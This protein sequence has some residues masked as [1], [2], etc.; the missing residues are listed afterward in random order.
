MKVSTPQYLW[1]QRTIIYQIYPRSFQDSNGDGIGDLQGIIIRLNYLQSLG[2][3]AIWLSPIFPSP[4]ADFGYDISDYTGI[5]SLFGTMEDFDQLLSDIHE[6]GMK[7]IL[8][9]VPN[10]SSDQHPWFLESRS[11]KD[12]PKRDWYI[13]HDAKA[14][15][16]PPNNWLSVFGGGA[17]EWDHTTNQYYY[18][19]FL[20]EQPDLNWRNPELQKAMLD[21]MRFWL[22]KGVDGFRVDVMWY[23][24]KDQEL[25]DNPVNPHYEQHRP[26]SEQ[27]IDVYST[28]QPEVLEIVKRM[29]EVLDEY[30]ERMMIGEIYLPI[31]RL[32]RYYGKSNDGAHL[33]FNF[34]LLSLPWDAEKIAAAIDEYEAALPPDGWPNWVLGNHDRLRLV[35]R[36]GLNQARIAAMLLLTLRGTPTIY[37]GEEIGMQDVNIPFEEIQ[38]PQGLNMPDKNLSRDPCRTPMQW[39]SKV[40]AG[41]SSGK[42]WLRLSPDFST[43][44]VAAQRDIPESMLFFYKRLIALRKHEPALA[45]GD[46]LS[47]YAGNGLLSFVRSFESKPKFL[48]LL[49]L[50]PTPA[51]FKTEHSEWKG[52]IILSTNPKLEGLRM[53]GSMEINGDEGMIISLD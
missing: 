23:M 3:E 17:W 12:N 46:Y 44:N 25:R 34:M 15:G 43:N 50:S 39:N 5:E 1:W 10:H 21:V 35:S 19:A 9:L 42:P 16:S 11:S 36:I 40:N 38:D 26:T 6:R 49:N 2:I 4:M 32:M 7:L 29:R 22:D 28:D 52:T 51:F 45:V 8:D 41:F 18:H 27:L 53:K 31:E 47:V 37:Y 30:D 20:K 13:W 24:I 33:P 14:D 48:I